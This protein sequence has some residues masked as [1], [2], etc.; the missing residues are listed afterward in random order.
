MQVDQC[1]LDRTDELQDKAIQIF[2]MNSQTELQ[3]SST[4]CLSLNGGIVSKKR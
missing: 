1:E 4:K 2:Y 3:S